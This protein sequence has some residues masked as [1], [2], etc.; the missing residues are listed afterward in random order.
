[1]SGFQSER[2]R[3]QSVRAVRPDDTAP[4]DAADTAREGVCPDCGQNLDAPAPD[5]CEPKGDS[6]PSGVKDLA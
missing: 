5:A 3:Y 6:C 4:D 2:D 1:M